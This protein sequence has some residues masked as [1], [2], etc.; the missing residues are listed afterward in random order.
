[1][2]DDVTARKGEM[3]WMHNTWM[4]Y[5]ATAEDTGGR[6][7]VLEQRLTPAGEPPR[8]VHA[9]EDEAFYV[10]EGR[11]EADD[12]RRH[13]GQRR[14]GA[15]SCFCPRGCRTACTRRP[16]RS[17]SWCCSRRPGSSSSSPPSASP[18]P[19]TNY[20]SPLP[21]TGQTIAAAAARYGVTVLPCR[22]T[23]PA[24]TPDVTC[25]AWSL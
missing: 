25:P 7:A 14:A 8:H 19:A 17:V 20:P 6:L 18:P 21:P 12:R 5:V 13:Q 11:L 24:A 16:L 4:R 10:L 22:L 23:R 15:S 2:T 3:I 9:N 1:M